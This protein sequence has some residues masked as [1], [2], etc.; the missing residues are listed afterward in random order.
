LVPHIC[1]FDLQ[2]ACLEVSSI[3]PDLD[4]LKDNLDTI[5]TFIEYC[6]KSSLRHLSTLASAAVFSLIAT[7]SAF[8]QNLALK[9]TGEANFSN[10]GSLGTGVDGIFL[11]VINIV[12]ILI[13]G[14]AVLYLLFYGYKYISSGGNP[15]KTKE[16]RG[17]L[18]NAVIGIIVVVAAYSIIRF[19]AR[20]GASAGNI[21]EG[22]FGGSRVTTGGTSTTT[23]NR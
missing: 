14:L 13:G 19:S 23:N 22:D 11:Q 7:T 20:I 10:A 6:M 18:I 17:G 4:L 16:A 9:P 5:S 2:T 12:T 3:S 15:D 1:S 21:L 8:A